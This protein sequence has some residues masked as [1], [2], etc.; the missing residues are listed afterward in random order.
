MHGKLLLA[1]A[2]ALTVDSPVFATDR[3]FYDI[4]GG[5]T[6][7]PKPDRSANK[8]HQGAKEM[9]RRRKQMK[10]GTQ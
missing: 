10:G 8:P 9:A 5:P 6:P 2:L 7:T 1:A 3:E 4:T